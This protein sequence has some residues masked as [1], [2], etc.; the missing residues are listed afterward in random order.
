MITVGEHFSFSDVDDLGVSKKMMD[1]FNVAK[2]AITSM[3]SEQKPT[4]IPGPAFAPT[5]TASTKIG[6]L[7]ITVGVLGVSIL[8]WAFFIRK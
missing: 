8:V 7:P 2:G 4:M 5:Q 3:T 6:W 1:T